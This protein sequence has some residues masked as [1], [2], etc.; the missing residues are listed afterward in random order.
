MTSEN[1]ENSE[2]SEYSENSEIVFKSS[3]NII[4]KN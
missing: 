3:D 4:I 2:H 1:S